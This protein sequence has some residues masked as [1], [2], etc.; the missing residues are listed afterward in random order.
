MVSVDYTHELFVEEAPAYGVPLLFLLSQLNLSAICAKIEKRYYDAAF[1]NRFHYRIE[2]LIKIWFVKQYRKLS[3][4]SVCK[5]LSHEDLSYLLTSDELKRYKNHTF[6]LPSPSTVHHFMHV[7]LGKEGIDY[8]MF[9]LGEEIYRLLRSNPKWRKMLI[10]VI[11]STPLEAS[12]YS[13]YAD[14]N[15][16][17]KIPMAKAHI[18]SVAGYPLFLIFSEGNEDDGLYG[19]RLIEAIKPL[20]PEF[21][22]CLCDGGYDNFNMYAEIFE[23]LHAIPIIRI[24]ENGVIHHEA[25]RKK[26]WKI[27]NSLWKQ[28]GDVYASHEDKLSF[29]YHL[30]SEKGKNSDYYKELVGKNLRNKN[31]TFYKEVEEE[32]KKRGRCE[33]FHSQI[34][35]VFKF[36]VK[37]LR[38]E[39]REDYVKLDFITSQ[40]MFLAYLQNGSLNQHLAG[41]V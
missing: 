26:I 19:H 41:F 22:S 38:K 15:P 35:D 37:H 20:N 16:H 4:R 5:S 40:A 39:S 3:F 2:L 29:L 13:I 30:P 34:K 28:G 33:Q 32:L 11:D 21:I 10:A 25:T 18:I 6:H 14:Y 27:V 23:G 9:L 24:R 17:Y 31:I 1:E 36:D 8:L 7:R 12:R